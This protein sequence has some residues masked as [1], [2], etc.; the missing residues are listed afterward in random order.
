MQNGKGDKN[1]ISDYKKYNENWDLIFSK[2]RKSNND[3]SGN[4]TKVPR[5]IPSNSMEEVVSEE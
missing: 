2:K 5:E 1:R 3:A 4:K